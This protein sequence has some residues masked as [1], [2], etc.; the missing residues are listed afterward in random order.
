M[1]LATSCNIICFRPSGTMIPIEQ[2]LELASQAGFKYYDISFWDWSLPG[3]PFLTDNWKYW[4]HNVANAA[5]YYGVE[6][7]QGHAY[8]YPFLNI[9][10]TEEECEC[11]EMLTRRSIDCC[12]ILG[13]KICVT[14][15]DTD[16][17][18]V[19]RVKSSKAKNIEY[20]KNLLEYTMR[21]DME[22][23]I[24]NMCNFDILPKAKYCSFTE[25]L[26]ELVDTFQNTVH[27]DHLGI[28]WDFEHAEIMKIDQRESLLA[29]GGMLKATHVS[30]THSQS[31]SD[32]MHIMPMFGKIDWRTI[33]KTLREINYQG[34][35][36]YEAHN[37]A[38]TLPDEVIP[39]A[40]KLSYEI[41]EYLVNLEK[42]VDSV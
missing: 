30:D 21:R 4:I 42:V 9:N 34:Y 8:T 18:S 6:F 41:G 28:C 1:K 39:T 2:T 33:V 32:L 36:S 29:I 5:A 40:L 10:M 3:S 31:D 7:V 23:A 26:I 35:F 13:V 19:D 17:R 16:W 12:S 37:Y 27:N 11:H 20:F 38:N 24:E 22:L 25:E 14:H 15:P